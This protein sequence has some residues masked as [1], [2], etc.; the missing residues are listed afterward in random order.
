MTE[1]NDL[2]KE[3][4]RS[5][6]QAVLEKA[7][8]DALFLSL[9]DGAIATD[10]NGIIQ[11]INPVALDIL[12]ITQ[13]QA[14]GSWYP[15]TVVALDRSNKIIQP[16]DRAI[17]RAFLTG[18]AISE[19]AYYRTKHDSRLP[20]FVTVSPT[21]LEGK[22]IGAVEIFHDISKEYR[23][24][25]M[26]SEFI[27]IASHQLRTPLSAINT[28]AEMLYGG[29]AGQLSKQ[30]KDFMK[31][32]LSSIDRMNELINTLL[33]VSRI[34]A[35]RLRINNSEIDY[36][37]VV[38]QI[39]REFRP[40]AREK[41]IKLICKAPGGR[42]DV[43]AD[44]L[45]LKEVCA[46]LLS[47]AL[48]Y[49]PSGG[50]VTLTLEKKNSEVILAVRDTGYGIPKASQEL[51]FS[52]FFRA[53]NVM[54]KDTHGTG[55]GLY[56]VKLISDSIGGKVWF[57]SRENKGSVFYFSVPIDAPTSKEQK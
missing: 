24:D 52:K 33:D 31:I 11:R 4:Q 44:P 54:Q 51:M 49:T 42:L 37:D 38:A 25:S 53:G 26:K 16:I 35:G 8:S 39:I 30:Q 57:K 15:T 7:Q 1:L 22:P 56:L 41:K 5:S 28:Y 21:I 46:N 29:Y 12:G 34:E 43:T 10:E 47:N 13:E 23:I 45:L 20:V 32:I 17:T 19:R 3:L 27:S 36:K 48:K 2:L 18:N 50:E 40:Q 55:L 14:L 9:G 6:L